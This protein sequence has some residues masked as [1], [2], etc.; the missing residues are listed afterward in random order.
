MIFQWQL[1]ALLIGVAILTPILGQR[2]ITDFYGH[3]EIRYRWFPVLVI[4]IPMIY[5]AGTRS[6]YMI[7]FGDTSAYVA[8][9]QATPTSIFA[10]LKNVTEGSK[11]VGF[12]VLTAMIKKV[13]GNREVVYLLM[14]A[15]VCIMCVMYTFREYSCNFIMSVFLFVASADYI[16]WTYNGI[17]QFIAVAIMFACA[18]L[19][20]KKKYVPL[21]IVILCLSTI[22]AS[23]LLMLPLIFIV[24]GKPWN[25]KTLLFAIGILTAIAF[26]DHFSDLVTT[27]MENSQYSGEVDQYLSTEGTNILRVAVYSMPA[28][29]SLFFKR[30]IERENNPFI[31]IA[32]NMSL[33][34]AL[35]YLLSA[36]T[37]G[38][39]LGRIPIMCSL[40]GYILLPWMIEKFFTKNSVRIVYALM[41]VA[42][43][44]FY[45]YQVHIIWLL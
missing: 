11:D 4:A 34:T 19:I 43:L 28:I 9:F 36:F 3:K 45:Y 26:V 1:F 35:C 17:R 33:I 24:Q 23:I 42:Y 25:K 44:C 18:G 32:V 37:S 5:L 13:I 8:G 41:I 30:R 40:Y 6:K 21:I 22:H 15:T 20:V 14:I 38:L 31:N 27:I 10:V 12:S 16:Q 39:F 29:V 2:Y 7:G